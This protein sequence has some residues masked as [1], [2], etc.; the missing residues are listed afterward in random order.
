MHS[1]V[2]QQKKIQSIFFD[3]MKNGEFSPY[4]QPKVNTET[5][6]IIGAEAL[7]RWIRNGEMMLPGEFIPVL[8]MDNSICELDFYIFEQVCKDIRRWIDE[9][10]EPVRIST[11]F[12]RRNLFDP[13]FSKHIRKI[14][15]DYD[16]PKQYIEVELTESI[17]EE[18]NDMLSRFIRDMHDGD[19]VIA[20]DDFG[21][22]YSSLSVLRDHK[23]DVLKL[24]KSFIDGH[25]DTKR[26]VVVVSNIAKMAK[27]LDMSV[28]TEG[29]ESW[30]QV[31]F[32]KSVN[33]NTV[34]GYLFDKPRPYDRI[35]EEAKNG[36]GLIYETP[37]ERSAAP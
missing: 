36:T 33:I 19:I 7:V 31:G 10:T 6:T 35:A 12:S 4:Y 29:V 25:T 17:S 30:D 18:E 26:D 34:Q 16:I 22:G 37:E 20:I 23:A 13:E 5:N 1:K 24:D 3:A 21:T 9:G 32:L 11:N 28:I 27:E 15:E 14:L 2:I 8:E